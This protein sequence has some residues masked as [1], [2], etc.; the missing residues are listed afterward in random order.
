MLKELC[1]RKESQTYDRKSARK[2]P[3]GLSNHIVAFANADGGTL[4]IGIEDDGTVTGIDGYQKNVNDILRVPFDFCRPSVRVATETIPCT[5]KN[6]K[7]D[8]LLVITIPQSP[9][10]HTNQ[11]DEVYYRMGDRSKKLNF[12]ERLELMYAKGSR[13]FEDEPVSDSSIDDIDLAYVAEYCTRIG[14]QKSPTEYILQNK[15]FVP[16]KGGKGELS[17][18]AILLFGKDPQRFFPRARVRFIRY[19]G[20]EAKVGAEMNVVKDEIFT[21]RILDVVQRSLHFVGSQIKEHKYLGQDGRFLTTPE[22]PEFAWKE[23]IVNAIAHRDYS[24]KGTD[25]QVKMFDD[26]ITVE[27]PGSLPGIVRL[28]NIRTVH[29]S[30]NPK[31]AEFLHEYR[32]VQE[33]GEGVD[34]LFTEM[35]RAGLPA[36][37]YKTV[38]FMVVATIQNKRTNDELNDKI[39]DKL[40]DELNP[41]ISGLNQT[42]LRVYQALQTIPH[43]SRQQ[44]SQTI[45]VSTSTVDRAIRALSGKGLIIRVGAKRKGYWQV[46]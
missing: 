45:G 5:D 1:S 40:N 28:N 14:Y 13:Y 7:P 8:H 41:A 11:Q 23:L 27:S 37:E 39:N 46:V 32:Y 18:A 10:L 35:E 17:S 43:A 24:I 34:R 26:R 9:E 20:T 31:I 30:R 2:E 38:S 6:G 29:F 42:E 36:P 12:D 4:V 3:K 33:F 22:Y 15:G 16:A 19:E 21:G 25:I 44:L